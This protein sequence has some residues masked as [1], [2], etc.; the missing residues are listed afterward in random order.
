M[1]RLHDTGNSAWSIL[2]VLIPIIGF[3]ILLRR[4]TKVGDPG[5]NKYG[6]PDNL[7]FVLAKK[8]I[9]SEKE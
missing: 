9:E 4:L 7:P 5:S 8:K 2:I 1:R 3:L 6:E